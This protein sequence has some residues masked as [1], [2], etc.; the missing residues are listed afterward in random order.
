MGVHG[1]PRSAG[2]SSATDQ[3]IQMGS[4]AG[5]KEKNLALNLGYVGWQQTAM[6]VVRLCCLGCGWTCMGKL[7]TVSPP[8][9]LGQSRKCC[10]CWRYIGRLLCWMAL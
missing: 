9:S 7:K 3:L 10:C 8:K 5:E 6:A 1:L 4:K 2:Q